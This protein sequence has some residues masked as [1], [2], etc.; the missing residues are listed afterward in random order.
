VWAL[1]LVFPPDPQAHVWN[2]L[3]VQGAMGFIFFSP[4]SHTWFQVGSLVSRLI[5]GLVI[6]VYIYIFIY[7]YKDHLRLGFQN[8]A[9]MLIL[10]DLNCLY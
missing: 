6:Y 2:Q 9:D 3:H 4:H 7:R 8:G 10:S 1:V 5:P